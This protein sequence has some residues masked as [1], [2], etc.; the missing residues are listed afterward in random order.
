MRVR[1][2]DHLAGQRMRFENLRVTDCLGAVVA[3]AQLAVELDALRCRELALLFLELQRDVEQAFLDSL[4]RHRL[5]QEGEVIAEHEN[6]AGIVD[7]RILAHQLL[8]KDRCHRRDVFVTEADV[9]QH[10]S[11]VAGLDGRYADLPR[12]GIHHPAAREN[13]LSQRHGST[14]R[15]GRVHYDITLQPGRVVIEEAPCSMMPRVISPSPAVNA[16][17]GM[18]SP[19]RTLSSIEKSVVVR[20]PRFWQFS[21]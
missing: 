8:E 7:L 1:A 9:R 19:R 17:S 6:R 12:G 4:G 20:T 10:E 14:R 5:G 13:L 3:Q 16:D 15:L 11:F 18:G 21:R 2:D